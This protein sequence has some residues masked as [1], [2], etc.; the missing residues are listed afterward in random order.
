[1]YKCLHEF[2]YKT[3]PDTSLHTMSDLIEAIEMYYVETTFM[4][5]AVEKK[6]TT[7]RK[8]Y[9]NIREYIMSAR[10]SVLMEELG[11]TWTDFNEI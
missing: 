6:P 8:K 4:M 7:I 11:C 2:T 3:V 10:P 5:K 1:M 9:C